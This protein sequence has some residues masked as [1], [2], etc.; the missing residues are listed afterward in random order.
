RSA[1]VMDRVSH[2][3]AGEDFVRRFAAALRATQLY[4]PTHPLVLRATEAL[5]DAAATLLADEGSVAIGF[6]GRDIIVSDM[7]IPRAWELYSELIRRLQRLGVERIAID[8]G[9]TPEEISTLL[10][11]LGHPERIAGR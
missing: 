3:R 9:V 4:A 6:L 8:R 10:L 11:T 2:L 1:G 7:P 5:G